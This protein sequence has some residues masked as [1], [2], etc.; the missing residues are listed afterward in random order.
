[1][2]TLNQVINLDSNAIRRMGE[3]ESSEISLTGLV[4][5]YRSIKFNFP[6]MKMFV[7]VF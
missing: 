3:F 2:F 1:M 5:L 4:K 7:L 6:S